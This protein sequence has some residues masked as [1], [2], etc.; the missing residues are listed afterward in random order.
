GDP[1]GPRG[2]WSGAISAFMDMAHSNGWTPA[3]LGTSEQGTLAWQRAGLRAV[4]IGD[5]AILS[6]QSF[7]L[8][9]PE[10][11]SVRTSVNRLRRAGYTTRVR[12]HDEIDPQELAHLIALA[13]L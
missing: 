9:A 2:Q 13:D 12:R 6:P 7:T 8:E 4:R 1:I 11:K 10:M 5:E 3:V